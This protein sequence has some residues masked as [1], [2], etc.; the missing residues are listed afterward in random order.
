[1]RGKK[2]EEKWTEPYRPERHQYTHDG[3]PRRKDSTKG[4]ERIFEEILAKIFPNLMRNVN[5]HIQKAHKFQV[6]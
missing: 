3:S 6:G 5:Q 4:A 1:M 2:N